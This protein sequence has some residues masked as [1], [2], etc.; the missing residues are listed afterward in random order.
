VNNPTRLHLEDPLEIDEARR[1]AR[2]MSEVRR[3]AEHDHEQAVEKAADA[4]AAYRKAYSQAFIKATG[5]AA[6]REAI[7]KADSAKECRERD[8]TAGMVKVSR[9]TAQGPRRGAVDA[10]E[11]DGLVPD[12]LGARMSPVH[13]LGRMEPAGK[14]WRC[15]RQTGGQKCRH[16]NPSRLRKCQQCGKPRSRPGSAPT[17]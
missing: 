1:A 4:E 14:T 13:V 15:Q 6:E 10:E 16:D 11:L 5:T 8:I 17:T 2:R 12:D 3:A 9:R 7:A